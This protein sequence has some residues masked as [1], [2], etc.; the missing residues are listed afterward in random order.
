MSIKKAVY[1][2]GQGG[3]TG[4]PGTNRAK[5]VNAV[6]YGICCFWPGEWTLTSGRLG[7]GFASGVDIRG[8]AVR[9][10]LP[11]PEL[12]VQAAVADSF[13]DVTRLNRLARLQVG[14]GP[15]NA[16]N[17]KLFD[18]GVAHE[19]YDALLGPIDALVKDKPQLIVVPSGALTALP[20]HLLLDEDGD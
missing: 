6:V 11:C 3:V 4:C 19:L 7:C 13:D 17:A 2:G 14:D 18:L 10:P 15:G 12:T 1:A 20:F 9:H 16:Q 8:R 5:A